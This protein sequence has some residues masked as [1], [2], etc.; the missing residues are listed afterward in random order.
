MNKNIIMSILLSI[1]KTIFD[2]FFINRD[3]R[4]TVDPRERGYV[5]VSFFLGV[6]AG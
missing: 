1:H 4:E 3:P 2:A 6:L 5:Y